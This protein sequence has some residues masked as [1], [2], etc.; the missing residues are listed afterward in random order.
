MQKVWRPGAKSCL[1]KSP[2]CQLWAIAKIY[3]WGSYSTGNIE[4]P[5]WR[6]NWALNCL[7]R[8][9]GQKHKL[10]ITS[11]VF[12]SISGPFT[13]CNFRHGHTLVC[14]RIDKGVSVKSFCSSTLDITRRT[15]GFFYQ[16]NGT[17]TLISFWLVLNSSINR[18]SVWATAWP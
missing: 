11:I 4:V 18:E 6:R 14:V 16:G 9:S 5:R 10:K 17:T 13:L 15:A 2:R 1:E 12:A 8:L 3:S 7:V